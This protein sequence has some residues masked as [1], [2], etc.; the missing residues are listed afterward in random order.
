MAHNDHLKEEIDYADLRKDPAKLFGYVYVYFLGALV[1][2]GLLYV[3][4]LTP[5]GKNAV[6]PSVLSDSSAFVRDIPYQSP[7][8]IPP[9][10][11]MELGTAT[12][13]LVARGRELYQANCASCHGNTGEGD[14]PAGLTL[15]PKARNFHSTEGWTNGPK[16]SDIY[17]TLEEGIVKNGMASFNYIP[18]ADRFALAHVVRSFMQNPPADTREDLQTLEATY[19]LSKGTSTP[20]TIPV[21][22]ATQILV[23][24]EI[25]VADATDRAVALF[26][27]ET[28]GAGG[29]IL[30]RLIT[31]E[32]RALYCLVVDGV[33]GRNLDDFVKILCSDPQSLGLSSQ[34]AQL[35]SEEWSELYRFV[36][37]LNSQVAQNGGRRG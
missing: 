13:E 10:D 9:V 7:R 22:K 31:H 11:V 34:V 18:P 26:N 8:E 16:V 23:R 30:R 36:Q 3:W 35:R 20:G 25:P 4:N 5:T 37:Q 21:R 32:R 33:P 14:G 1:L 17:R 2:L 24:E 12:S 29:S 28:D 27:R 6:T 19:Q 15:N